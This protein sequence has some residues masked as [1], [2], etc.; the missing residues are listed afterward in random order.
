LAT[1][2]PFKARAALD[3]YLD[4]FREVFL[5]AMAIR[6]CGSAALDLA[7]TAA[8]T[9]DAFFEF[10]LSPWDIAA[11]ALLIEEAG[12][13]VCDLD[14][15]DRYL[16]SGNVLAGSPGVWRQL[17]DAVALHADEDLLDRLVPGGS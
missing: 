9:F 1:G 4:V 8:G 11:G 7:Y 16:E 13:G 3:V 12:G 6:R 5:R 15:G 10:R 17:R 14:G 2:Y